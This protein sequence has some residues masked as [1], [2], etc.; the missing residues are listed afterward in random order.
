MAVFHNKTMHEK[1]LITSKFDLLR[2]VPISNVPYI[3][4]TFM[5]DILMI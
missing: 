4:T 2:Y 3:S 1:S 5:L